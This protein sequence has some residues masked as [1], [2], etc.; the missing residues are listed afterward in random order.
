[1]KR[2]FA[3][4]LL[5]AVVAGLFIGCGTADKIVRE[6]AFV[7]TV[8]QLDG[9]TETIDVKTT[10]STVGAA[11]LEKGI[12]AGET[13]QYGLMV[14]TVNGQVCDYTKTGTWWKFLINGEEALQG[15]DVT[16]IADGAVYGFA[17]TLA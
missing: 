15:V 12:I 17:V 4:I 16:E 7:L 14:T 3:C 11:L 8:E 6:H 5:L 13:S 2:F 9:T 10:E 1:M